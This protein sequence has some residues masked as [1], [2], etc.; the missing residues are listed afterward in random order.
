M[1]VNTRRHKSVTI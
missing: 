1:I